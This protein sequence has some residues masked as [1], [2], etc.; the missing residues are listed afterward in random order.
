MIVT[1]IW[2]DQRGSR[3]GFGPH[4][5]LLSCVA[6]ELDRGPGWHQK[7]K[8]CSA[9]LASV[10]KKGNGV[11][12]KALRNETETLSKSGPLFAVLDHDQV[13][14]LW[15]KETQPPSCIP[16]IVEAMKRDAPGRYELVL[17]RSNIETVVDAACQALHQPQQAKSTPDARDHPLQK[18]AWGTP[19]Q[20]DIVRATVADF[21]RLV[22]KVT[23]LFRIQFVCDC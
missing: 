9:H 12:L 23:E 21:D 6:D 2:E 8:W 15:P 20:R 18:L 1:V 22:R 11:V 7:R 16:G 3:Q 5:L 4:D 19:A 10:P 13:V 14:G 17:L